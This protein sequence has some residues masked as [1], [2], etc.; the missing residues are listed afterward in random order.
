MRRAVREMKRADASALRGLG[1]HVSPLSPCAEDNVYRQ[2]PGREQGMGLTLRP[3]GL[4]AADKDRSDYT[5]FSGEFAVGRIYEERGAPADLKWFWAITGIFGTP[6][7][8][9]MDGPRRRSN[10]RRHSSATAG[11]SGWPGRSWPRSS[12]RD[13]PSRE[14]LRQYAGAAYAG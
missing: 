1:S 8:M 9:R 10:W 2:A 13:L 4:G 5:L 6:A 14:V 7:D 11:A 12:A 3:P